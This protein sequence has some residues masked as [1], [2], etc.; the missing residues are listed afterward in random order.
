MTVSPRTVMTVSARRFFW[1]RSLAASLLFLSAPA[2]SAGSPVKA[3][4][5]WESLD[6]QAWHGYFLLDAARRR[7]ADNIAVRVTCL[8][9]KGED[10][11]WKSQ[12]GQEEVNES[13]RMAVLQ[14][15]HAKQFWNYLAGRSLNSWEGGWRDAARYA[16]VPPEKLEKEV[17]E[18]GSALLE[19]H[20]RRAAEFKV[21]RPSLFI[22]GKPYQGEWKLIPLIESLNSGLPAAKHFSMPASPAMEAAK[23]PRFWV[24]ISSSEP[25]AREDQNLTAAISRTFEGVRPVVA[26]YGAGILPPEL[27]GLDIKF[28]PA[29][30][31]E[32]TPAVRSVFRSAIERG[33]MS[34]VN[35]YMVVSERSR[36]GVF[37]RQPRKPG[38]LEIFV[39][40]QCPYGV[41]AENS[42][43]EAVRKNLVP[44]GTQVRLRYIA[45]VVAGSGAERKFQSLHGTAEWEEDVRQLV[46]QE[47]YPEKF[48]DYLLQRNSDPSS[49]MWEAAA[50]RAGIDSA[51]VLKEFEK[52]RE[53]LA[54]DARAGSE[55]GINSSPTF[56]WEGRVLAGG[57]A[58]L[59]K[60]SGFENMPLQNAGSGQQG[61]GK[62]QNK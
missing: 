12:R 20:L 54:L 30:V 6:G 25:F 32:D 43:I 26:D 23:P 37:V 9:K 57:L 1:I 19:L 39:M 46:I 33:M 55:L 31:L 59:K 49:S 5:F 56:L 24:I 42:V 4:L 15:F 3:E 16:G 40:S 27:A 13:M 60:I 41:Q 48:F 58:G 14:E 38:L 17:K 2:F 61:C 7:M 51:A 53:L 29:Y 62:N 18:K 28:L 45:D 44:Q 21:E 52:G 50:G 47:R 22:G 36:E 11:S 8:V 10:G 35:G 34:S